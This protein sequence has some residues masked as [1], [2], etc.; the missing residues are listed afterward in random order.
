MGCGGSKGK[1]DPAAAE[2]T[3]EEA[4]QAEQERLVDKL[5]RENARAKETIQQLRAQGNVEQAKELEKMVETLDAIE[6]KHAAAKQA[7]IDMYINE[8]PELN[9]RIQLEWGEALYE[10]QIRTRHKVS[11]LKSKIAP[12]ADLSALFALHIQ[13]MYNGMPLENDKTWEDYKVKPDNSGLVQLTA[14]GMFGLKD[15]DKRANSLDLFEA[16]AEG[17]V[18]DV[19]FVCKYAPPRVNEEDDAK[20]LALHLASKNGHLKVV[21]TL[22]KAK[23]D[24]SHRDKYKHTPLH[25][26]ASKGHDQVLSALLDAGADVNAEDEDGDTALKWAKTNKRP[27]VIKLLQHAIL[28]VQKEDKKKQAMNQ[29]EVES[30]KKNIEKSSWWKFC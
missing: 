20:R 5:S 30:L 25:L 13:L 22:L 15:Q 29:A 11:L 8:S 24:V 28:E 19:E 27:K 7:Q 26:A 17:E 3:P 4:E 23:S 1:P 9:I 10:N 21:E 12:K 18:E 14:E 16:A 2:M 6:A